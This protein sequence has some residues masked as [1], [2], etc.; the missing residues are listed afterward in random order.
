[1]YTHSVL[2]FTLF[3]FARIESDVM[4]C[5]DTIAGLSHRVPMRPHSCEISMYELGTDRTASS[6]S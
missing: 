5:V 6:G 2:M 3:A 4:K 1:M